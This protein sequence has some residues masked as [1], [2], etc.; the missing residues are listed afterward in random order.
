MSYIDRVQEK[1]ERAG[2]CCMAKATAPRD[3]CPWHPDPPKVELTTEKVK[4]VERIADRILSAEQGTCALCGQEM[5]RTPDDAWHPWTV[6]KACPPEVRMNGM[7]L[8]EWGTPG[9][10]GREHFRSAT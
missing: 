4:R 3:P 5:I 7:S 2:F 6:E 1:A 10:P 8:S 9:R